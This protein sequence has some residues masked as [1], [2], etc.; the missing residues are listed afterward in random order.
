[1]YFTEGSMDPPLLGEQSDPMDPNASLESVP[2]FQ[3]KPIGTSDI[4]I[5]VRGSGP[6][7][8]PSGSAIY[9]CFFFNK[10][11]DTTYL[12]LIKTFIKIVDP[13]MTAATIPIPANTSTIKMSHHTLSIRTQIQTLK[14]KLN[15]CKHYIYS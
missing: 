10:N 9:P 3:R 15:T 5:V 4:F 12:F 1:M 11:H 2:E 13:T 7:V 8:P 6:P 14:I